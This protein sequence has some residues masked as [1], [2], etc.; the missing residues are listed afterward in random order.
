MPSKNSTAAAVA[1]DVLTADLT[2]LPE[3]TFHIGERAYVVR[4]LP[5]DAFIG[6]GNIISDNA[7]ELG[8]AGLFDQ[9]AWEIKGTDYTELVRKV[10]KVWRRVPGV[11]D[12]AFALLLS[13]EEGD[14][15]EYIRKHMTPRQL[16]AV[17]K[18]FMRTNPWQDLVEGFFQLREEWSGEAQAIA[19]ESNR[20]S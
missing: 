15:G 1:V 11:I 13:G 20:T 14:D 5:V 7:E 17:V 16:L 9:A 6:L 2:P 18:A 3:A 19:D 12:R 10:A 8:E 4:E